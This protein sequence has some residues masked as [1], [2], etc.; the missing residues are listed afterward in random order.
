MKKKQWKKQGRFILQRNTLNLE[1]TIKL[2]R[3]V[4]P[5]PPYIYQS[6][7]RKKR[8][9]VRWKIRRFSQQ[10][11]TIIPLVNCNEF[12]IGKPKHWLHN[13][14]SEHFT[15]LLSN[16]IISALADHGIS[17]GHNLKWDHFEI[18]ATGRSDLQPSLNEY[19]GSENLHLYW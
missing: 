9:R 6:L 2:R 13:P 11:L 10:P 16:T 8:K 4:P 19:A 3:A 14:K 1:K 7:Q 17:T 18:L 15:A 5:S 12:Y